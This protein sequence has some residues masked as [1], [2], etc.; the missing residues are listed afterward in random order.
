MDDD[1]DN[2]KQSVIM[3]HSRNTYASVGNVP[4]YCADNM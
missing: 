1:K 4:P 3:K 2:R